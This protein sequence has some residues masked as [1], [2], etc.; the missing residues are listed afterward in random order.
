MKHNFR[1]LE[2]VFD[3]LYLG[4]AL[5]I[6]VILMLSSI[7]NSARLVAGIAVLTLTIGDSFHLVPR[8]I[9]ITT[10]N[11]SDRIYYFLGRG[12]QIT[13]ITM[14]IFYLLLWWIGTMVLPVG[15]VKVYSYLIFILVAIRIIMCIMPQNKWLEKDADNLWGI[16]RNVPFLAIGLIVATLFFIYRSSFQQLGLMWVAI[17]ISFAFYMP[18]VIWADKVPK[19]GM[20]MLPKSCTYIWIL[21]MFLS[22]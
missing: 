9:H 11:V 21:I 16:W 19:I 2:A 8:I 3:V 15:N 6:G 4:I 10:P 22:L 1:I 20:L 14:A 13:S 12:K 18:V 7:N 5:I 17:L